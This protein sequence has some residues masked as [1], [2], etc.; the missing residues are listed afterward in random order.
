[1]NLD[2]LYTLTP[3]TPEWEAER[4]RLINLE[5]SKAPDHRRPNLRALQAQLD[6]AR[7]GMSPE[8]FMALICSRVKDNIEN[9]RDLGQCVKNMSR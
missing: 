1:M 9:I 3:N 7:A 2:K 6:I 8:E 4:T 5:I